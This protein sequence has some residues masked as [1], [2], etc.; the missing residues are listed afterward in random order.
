QQ[1]TLMKT[2]FQR[3]FYCL[4]YEHQT[5]RFDVLK[6]TLRVRSRFD[7]NILA[8][9]SSKSQIFEARRK[10]LCVVLLHKTTRFARN[11]LLKAIKSF[12]LLFLEKEDNFYFVTSPQ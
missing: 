9:C 10:S 6:F 1:N 2:S 4:N 11:L 5:Q 7:S 8:L 3:V 12:L